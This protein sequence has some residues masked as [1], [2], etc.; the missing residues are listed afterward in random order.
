[1]AMSRCG[2][3]EMPLELLLEVFLHAAPSNPSQ[4]MKSLIALSHVCALWR[5]IILEKT[6]LWRIVNLAELDRW[7]ADEL[8]QRSAGSE[9]HVAA[10]NFDRPDANFIAAEAPRFRS[11]HVVCDN[12]NHLLGLLSLVNNAPRLREV[13]LTLNWPDKRSLIWSIIHAD[14]HTTSPRPP[15]PSL[16][17]FRATNAGL[18]LAVSFFRPTLR[19]LELTNLRIPPNLGLLL[20]ALAGTPLLEVLS[21]TAKQ[22]MEELYHE[23]V[24]V[25]GVPS[26]ELPNLR[27][28]TLKCYSRTWRTFFDRLHFPASAL[29]P[30]ALGGDRFVVYQHELRSASVA[31]FKSVLG[32]LLSKLAGVGI[33]GVVPTL[34]ALEFRSHGSSGFRIFAW[35]GI[36]QEDIE[37]AQPSLSCDCRYSMSLTDVL[38]IFGTMDG[39]DDVLS[40]V[41]TLSISSEINQQGLKSAGWTPM[42]TMP[43]L[44]NLT[45]LQLDRVPQ[46]LRSFCRLHDIDQPSTG[47]DFPA[48]AARQLPF[49]KLQ[50]L[51]LS[52]YTLMVSDAGSRRRNSET[53]VSRI[54]LKTLQERKNVGFPVKTLVL[55]SVWPRERVRVFSEFK[56]FVEDVLWVRET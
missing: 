38:E 8:L 35:L 51:S 30:T 11:Y 18:S 43:G 19:F 24:A 25:D 5:T 13:S 12:P 9:L 31:S 56:Q 53:S 42:F 23:P 55:R 33:L 37:D 46:I 49:P 15:L 7:P 1:M 22:P 14:G 10:S 50:V 6:E 54:L 47:I 39:L 52:G 26:V 20:D 36:G 48:P 2:M 29:S 16:E 40:G 32:S 41:R 44:Q 27:S 21:I 4:S 17:I 45:T 3:H 34:D 28:L